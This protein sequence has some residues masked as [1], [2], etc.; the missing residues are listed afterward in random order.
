MVCR[1]LFRSRSEHWVEEKWLG[2]PGQR[3]WGSPSGSFHGPSVAGVRERGHLGFLGRA[4]KQI[5]EPLINGEGYSRGAWERAGVGLSH[6]S[7]VTPLA[8]WQMA[9]ESHP[10][11]RGSSISSSLPTIPG[12]KP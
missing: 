5:E 8:F 10:H 7:R 6:L 3:A 11:L 1:L 12:G 4:D 2:F 9:F